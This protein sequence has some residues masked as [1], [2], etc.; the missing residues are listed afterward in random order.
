MTDDAG[1][2]NERKQLINSTIENNNIINLS[3]IQTSNQ[4]LFKNDENTLINDQ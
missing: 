3:R 1:G 4:Q 2:H